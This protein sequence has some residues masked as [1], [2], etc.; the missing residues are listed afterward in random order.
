M[1]VLVFLAVNV[2]AQSAPLPSWN[3]TA[4]K[5]AIMAFV[6]RITKEGGPD[7]VP[8][9][10]RIAVFDNDGTLWAEQPLYF[11][12][13]F[14]MDR[15]RALAPQHPEW[16]DKEPFASLI[17][18][19]MTTALAGG[20]HALLDI[21]A[22]THFGMTTEE[23][24]RV[25][26]EWLAT[27]KHPKT[28]RPYTEMIYQPMVE[29]LAFLRAN[30]FKTFIVSGGGVEFMR[31]WTERIYGIPPEQVVGSSGKLK[32]EMRGDKPVLVKLPEVDFVDDKEGK[33]A[34]IQKFIGRRPI[35]AFGNSDGDLQMLQWTAAGSG[36]RLMMLVHHDD[37]KREWAYDRQSKIG[38]LDRALDEAN[39]RGWAVVSM[40][41]DWR[42]VFPFEGH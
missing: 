1:W 19:D 15:V 41:G 17:K 34:G 6:G 8:P 18:G 39:A 3:D 13:L 12:V 14:A 22:A 42:R 36:P 33:P 32:F 27:A 38:R 20:E 2:F 24:E 9:A 37:A 35:A 16:R 28:G 5:K 11:Q 30:G 4:A 7:F 29:L 31:P 26:K 10:E 25:V 21:V 23:F 40:K